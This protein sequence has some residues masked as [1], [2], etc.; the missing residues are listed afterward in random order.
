MLCVLVS[1]QTITR[2]EYFATF[3]KGAHVR[4]S[5]TVQF[6]MLGEVVFA[7]ETFATSRPF[8]DEPPSGVYIPVGVQVWLLS[9]T[10]STVYPIAHER[11]IGATTTLT[12]R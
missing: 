4:I 10:L 8:T 9:E 12:V 2:A 6:L 7:Y 3:R 1:N 5:I 11:L